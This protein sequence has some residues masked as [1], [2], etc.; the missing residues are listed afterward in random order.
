[1]FAGVV[2][3]FSLRVASSV[4]FNPQVEEMPE[5]LKTIPIFLLLFYCTYNAFALWGQTTCISHHLFPAEAHSIETI[6]LFFTGKHY[7]DFVLH[8]AIITDYQD[9][10]L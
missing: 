1:M 3:L 9:M 7:F 2:L 6:G 4:S 5:Y 8:C 10:S